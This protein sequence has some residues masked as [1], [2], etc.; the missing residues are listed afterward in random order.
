MGQGAQRH[1]FSLDSVDEQVDD[2]SPGK[3]EPVA[4]HKEGSNSGWQQG[5]AWVQSKH[6]AR[7][8]LRKRTKLYLI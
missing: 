6:A 4:S 7:F 3:I 2:G 1:Q 5:Y 8:L